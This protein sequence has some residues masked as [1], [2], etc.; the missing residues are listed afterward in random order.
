MRFGALGLLLGCIDLEEGRFV[1]EISVLRIVEEGQK[2]KILLL[3]DR[4]IFVRV[5]LRAG[6]RCSHPHGH[7]G[8]D[9]V[10]HG[11]IAEFFIVC[12]AFVIG[13]GIAVKRG[14]NQSFIVGVVQ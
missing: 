12:A 8:V 4:V 11:G 14:A 9:A 13:H 1:L 5:T 7:R 6:H 2:A 3:R 10:H